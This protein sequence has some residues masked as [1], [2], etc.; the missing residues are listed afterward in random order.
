M[1]RVQAVASRRDLKRFIEYPYRKYKDDPVWVPPLLISEWEKFDPKR[2][3]F[4]HHARMDLYLAFRGDRVVGRVAAIDDDNHNR[5]HGDNLLFFGF[6]EAEDEEAALQLFDATLG[7]ARQLGRSLVRGPANPTMNDGSGF[8][9]DAFDT[10]PYVMMPQN[11]PEYPAFAET[12]GFEKVMDLYAWHF[13]V[14]NGPS[15]RLSRLAER[16]RRRERPHIRSA[17]MKKLDREARILKQ[18]YNEAWEQNWG[19]VKFTD[20]EFDHLVDEL[21]LILE[22]DLALFLEIDGQ[23]AGIAITIPDV[24]QVLKQIHGR[25]LPFGIFKL[26][27]RRKI[28]DR[29]RLPILGVMPEFRNRGLELVLIDEIARRGAKHGYVEGECSWVLES[30]SAMNR[31]IEAAGLTLYKTYRLFQKTV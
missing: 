30:N 18:V 9:I 12:A 20:A 6:F 28:I 31:G 15:E 7:R 24:N 23:I 3:P 14:L 19:F 13:D 29:G 22:P 4:F 10:S 21:K 11:P 1:T 5:T 27:N 2:N 16:V 8:Q 25:L 17:D 26:L